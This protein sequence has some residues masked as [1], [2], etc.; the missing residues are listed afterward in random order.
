VVDYLRW[1]THEGQQQCQELHYAS[2]PEGFI[3]RID[4]KLERIEITR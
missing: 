1:T 4:R 2:L 3:S